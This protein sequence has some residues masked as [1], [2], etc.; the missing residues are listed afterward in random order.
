MENIHEHGKQQKRM[1]HKKL[2][3]TSH[4]DY[5]EKVQINML[6]FKTDLF[7]TREKI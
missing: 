4:K 5:I 6:L 1:S 7:I 3:L 2:F